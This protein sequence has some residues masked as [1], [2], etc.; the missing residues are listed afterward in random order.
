MGLSGHV[1]RAALAGGA[2]AVSAGGAW[3]Q[4]DARPRFGLLEALGLARPPIEAEVGL[5][6]LGE[7]EQAPNLYRVRPGE[8][9]GSIA[10]R[11]DGGGVDWRDLCAINEGRIDSCDL[12]V[13][14]S[15]IVIPAGASVTP[16]PAAIEANGERVRQGS[17]ETQLETAV[18]NVGPAADA[19]ADENN[20]EILPLTP[21][22][23]ASLAILFG[24]GGLD[25]AFETRKGHTIEAVDGGVII[26][27]HAAEKQA[28]GV[29][30]GAFLR[31]PDEFEAAAS[32]QTIRVTVSASSQEA[33]TFAAAYSTNDV[34]NSGWRLVAASPDI[35]YTAFDYD[36]RAIDRGRG[37]FLGID[38]DPQGEGQTIVIHAI[39]LEVL[40]VSR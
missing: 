26:S 19:P 22:E 14:G 25:L 5:R 37:D 24:A 6:G 2:L 4:D 20:A 32:G 35:E 9:L 15:L 27:G 12:I 18:Q 17:A 36:V 38:P 34:G 23:D 8:T 30:S 40:G 33:I 21:G 7:T 10:R 28:S 29:T 11:I 16:P 13:S 39:L 1:A 3:A 31:L